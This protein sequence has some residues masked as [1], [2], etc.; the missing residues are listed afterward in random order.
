MNIVPKTTILEPSNSLDLHRYGAVLKHH[1]LAAML[2]CSSVVILAALITFSQKPT[3]EAEGKLLLNKVN[4]VSSLAG[5]AQDA[6]ALGGMTHLSNPL[7]TEAEVI[8]SNPIVQKTIVQLN[9]KT[10]SGHPLK[11]A[12][13]LKRFQVKPVRGADVLRMTYRS[14]DPEEAARV[15]NLMMRFY[16]ENNVATNRAEAVAAREFITKQ[17][18]KTETTVLQAEA[19]LRRFKEKNKVVDLTEEAKSAVATLSELENKA[20]QTRSALVDVSSRSQMLQQQIG[21]T[22][23]QAIQ[24]T[25]LNQSPAVQEALGQLRKVQAE[26]AVEQTRY[27]SSHPKIVNL[28]RKQASLEQLLQERVQPILRTRL[29]TPTSLQF[30]EL[31]QKITADLVTLEAERLGLENN[32]GV[33]RNA[34]N[35]YRQRIAQLPQLEQTLRDLERRADIAQSTYALLLKKLQEVE[36]TENQ[37]VGNARVISAALVPTD[38][39]TPKIMLNL[40]LGGVLGV[41]LG[42]LV[43]LFLESRDRSIKTVEAA[44]ELFEYTLL[45]TIP[46]YDRKAATLNQGRKRLPPLLPVRDQPHSLVSSAYDMLL[47]NLSFLSSDNPLKIITITSSVPMEG[48]SSVS[49][50]LAVA[51][52]QTGRRV[53]LVDG[54]LRRPCQHEIWQLPKLVGLTDVL[55][56][57][58][59]IEQALQ[60]VLPNLDIMLAGTSPPNPV[61]LLDSRHAVELFEQLAHRY[62]LVIIDTPPVTLA[63]DARLLGKVADGVM[64][65][66][67]PGIVSSGSVMAAKNLL[68]QSA[69][70]ILGLVINGVLADREPGGYY[71]DRYAQSY[72]GD[73]RATTGTES[74]VYHPTGQ[75]GNGNSSNYGTHSNNGTNGHHSNNG[76]HGNNGSHPHN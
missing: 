22:P 32:L 47:A 71:Y 65:V 18:P 69:Q 4:R 12:E 70:N 74:I 57:Q 14:K 66:A 40:A 34:Y 76:N 31:Q 55:V 75:Q 23:Q 3:Y 9:L 49:A 38:P 43:A 58:A 60:T 10:N 62:D 54:D 53:L 42:M 67:R 2:T 41:L 5:V 37:N 7:D 25:S 63:A 61:A 30:G 21:V 24:L 39:V 51:A 36:V 59:T 11:P 1:W 33:M 50:N 13:F 44:R 6:E 16:M 27:R 35:A 15:V 20:T 17:L 45:G 46:Y 64:I 52:T 28:E 26:L 19:A 29:T 56:G 48:K 73:D 8:R 68:D 72:Y